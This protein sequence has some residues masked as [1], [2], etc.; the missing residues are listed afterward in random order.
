MQFDSHRPLQKT[1]GLGRCLIFHFFQIHAKSVPFFRETSV[2][3]LRSNFVGIANTRVKQFLRSFDPWSSISEAREASDIGSDT[4]EVILS[5][6]DFGCFRTI[7]SGLTGTQSCE[8][9][10]DRLANGRGHREPYR[11]CA[12]LD[13]ANHALR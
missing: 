4:H 2:A 7:A 1:K 11:N 5:Y 6:P 10:N 9:S 3:L 13:L 8:L 12:L